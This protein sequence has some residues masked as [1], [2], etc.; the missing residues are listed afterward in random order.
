MTD[1]YL[2]YMLDT[3]ADSGDPD[4]VE[5]HAVEAYVRRLVADAARGVAPTGPS[6]RIP[7]PYVRIRR[8]G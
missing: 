6:P 8:R 3:I 5:I 7:R 4:R 2:R 1:A